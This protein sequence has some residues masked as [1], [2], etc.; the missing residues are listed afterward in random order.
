MDCLL[1]GFP[2]SLL[3]MSNFTCACAVMNVAGKTFVL[4]AS[5]V[6]SAQQ[7][8]PDHSDRRVS[9]PVR[10]RFSQARLPSRLWHSYLRP[11]HV[12]SAAAYS[13]AGGGS[14]FGGGWQGDEQLADPG[15][16]LP[17]LVTAQVISGVWLVDDMVLHWCC[18]SQLLTNRAPAGGVCL[19]ELHLL[20]S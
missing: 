11:A 17:L 14:A 18:Q 9:Y 4:K 16:M 1:F 20:H 13:G 12:A 8:C 2:C 10:D 3:A 19:S 15:W 6:A 7:A 5:L